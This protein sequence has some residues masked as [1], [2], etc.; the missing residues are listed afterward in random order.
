MASND[1]C[2]VSINEVHA[3][4]TYL[5]NMQILIYLPIQELSLNKVLP[6][7]WSAPLCLES[8]TNEVD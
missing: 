2:Q 4:T 1:T 5:L 6:S 8:P 3:V 7:Q